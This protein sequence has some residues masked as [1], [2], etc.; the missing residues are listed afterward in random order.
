MLINLS[1]N[2]VKR[3]QATQKKIEMISIRDHK[4]T[5]PQLSRVSLNVCLCRKAKLLCGKN[6]TCRSVVVF[7]LVGH[8]FVE[9]KSRR[10]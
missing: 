2:R 5:I 7:Y 3:Q 8:D 1:E 10:I 9:F 4:T 6:I